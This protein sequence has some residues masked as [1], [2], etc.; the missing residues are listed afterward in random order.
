MAR[1][2]HLLLYPI[3]LLNISRLCWGCLLAGTIYTSLTVGVSASDTLMLQGQSAYEAGEYAKAKEY[4]LEVLSQGE[5]SS[6]SRV[7][8]FSNLSSISQKLGDWQQAESY[9]DRAETLLDNEPF[10]SQKVYL[11]AQIYMLRGQG[12]F[13]QGRSDRALEAWKKAEECYQES[14]QVVGQIESQVYQ[15][16]ALQELGFYR[17][18]L[19]KLLQIDRAIL[20]DRPILQAKVFHQLGNIIRVVGK[21]D[22]IDLNWSFDAQPEAEIN[23]VV[24]SE[25]LLN[26]SYLIYSTLK[27]STEQ[28]EVLLDLGNTIFVRY[29]Q[30]KDEYQRQYPIYN[31][32]DRQLKRQLKEQFQ[33]LDRTFSIYQ[34][35]AKLGNSEKITTTQAKLNAIDVLMELEARRQD[36]E[37][38]MFNIVSIDP[39]TEKSL[40]NI[41]GELTAI[42]DDLDGTIVSSLNLSLYLKLAN[43][44]IHYRKLTRRE[45]DSQNLENLLTKAEQQAKKLNDL[46]GLSY[47]KGYRGYWLE[48]QGDLATARKLTEEAILIT[49]NIRA[50]EIRYLWEWQLGRILAVESWEKPHKTD[51]AIAAYRSALKNLEQVREDMMSLKNPDFR[52]LF[53]DDVEPVYREFAE[54]LLRSPEPFQT[55]LK[56]DAKKIQQEIATE[57][58]DAAISIITYEKIKE[59]ISVIEGLQVAE[60]EDYLRCNLQER[61][62]TSLDRYLQG[63][64]QDNAALIYPILLGDRLRVIVQLPGQK[65]PLYY[66]QPHSISRKEIHEKIEELRRAIREKLGAEDNTIFQEI[67]NLILG[68]LEPELEKNAVKNLVFVMDSELRNIPLAALHDGQN[69]AIERYSIALN[70][71]L[72]IE[73]TQPLILSETAILAAG[74]SEQNL[75]KSSLPY[76]EEELDFI[77]NHFDRAEVL[78]NSEFTIPTFQDKIKVNPFAIVHLA[79]HGVFSS[80]PEET[81]LWVYQDRMTLNDLSQLL[82]QQQEQQEQA[83][84]L[85][86]LSACQTAIGDKRATLGVAGI[87][88]RSGAK[89]TLATLFSVDDE[90]TAKLIKTFYQQLDLSN[91]SKAEALRQAQLTLLQGEEIKY[92]QPYYWSPYI[93]IGNW[94]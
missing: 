49:E 60:L 17:E 81:I 24:Q 34:E 32:E 19:T 26:E 65:E 38:Q 94:Q 5:N 4:L 91:T 31:D 67:Y 27:Y 2:R 66:I 23:Y 14:Q 39:K 47:S 52:F 83:I 77:K 80:N 9:L 51:S 42:G 6:L 50:P 13:L 1:K 37:P 18:A 75:R 88:T 21:V 15:A 7:L 3:Q 10:S 54:L 85:L 55:A 48:L 69:Y 28:V 44:Y 90:L 62:L 40:Q 61:S 93:L 68:G 92:Q 56:S 12:E 59:A 46:R 22:E 86:V 63:N 30:L 89:S 36:F 82:S 29:Y 78:L 11:L 72:E 8:I 71:G 16:I 64:S 87:A 58:A 25:R 76:V 33:L 70:L 53:R 84:E 43:Q 74:V 79:T 57:K 45:I 73:D 41:A 35:V 20:M